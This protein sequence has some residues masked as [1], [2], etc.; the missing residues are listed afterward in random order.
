M[1]SS[2]LCQVQNQALCRKTTLVYKLLQLQKFIG[3][4]AIS[5]KR[6]DNL[7]NKQLNSLCLKKIK[8][9]FPKY[10]PLHK[11]FSTILTGNKLTAAAV[12]WGNYQ[13]YADGG[14]I[15][16]KIIRGTAAVLLE[17]EDGPITL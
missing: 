15:P 1:D 6:N 7:S 9:F 12:I 2:F 13:C 17:V 10:Q 5:P 16:G 14:I 3:A 4:V 11:H 8:T